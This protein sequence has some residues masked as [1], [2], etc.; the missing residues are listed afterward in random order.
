MIHFSK[1]SMREKKI[2]IFLEH[3]SVIKGKQPKETAKHVSHW[4]IPAH[5]ITKISCDVAVGKNNFVLSIVARDWRGNLV[6]AHSKK[7]HTNV[8]V[9][10]EAEAFRWAIWVAS[11]CNLQK[12][13][14]VG[15]SKICLE[16]IIEKCLEILWKIDV[17]NFRERSTETQRE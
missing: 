8:P 15:D 4:S 13:V 1:L 10:A 9:Q 14:I 7:A 16:T 2:K 5:S 11:Q 12:V 6:F 3:W 17:V